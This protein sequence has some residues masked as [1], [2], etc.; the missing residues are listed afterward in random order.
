MGLHTHSALLAEPVRLP[1]ATTSVPRSRRMQSL[2]A[3][4][5]GPKPGQQGA[6]APDEK[7]QATTNAPAEVI[8][9]QG[10]EDSKAAREAQTPNK[11]EGPK[12][13]PKK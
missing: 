12:T 10:A 2:R 11:K 9:P 4:S 13:P 3:Y 6:K 5:T 8:G 1:A 7:H